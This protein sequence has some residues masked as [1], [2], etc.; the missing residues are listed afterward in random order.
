MTE[1]STDI[2]GYKMVFVSRDRFDNEKGH[3]D[4]I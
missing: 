2:V 4:V 1:F 3:F